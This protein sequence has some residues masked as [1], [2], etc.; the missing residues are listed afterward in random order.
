[1]AERRNSN[2]RLI[3]KIVHHMYDTLG[4]VE[5]YYTDYLDYKDTY[6][7]AASVALEMANTHLKLYMKWHEAVKALIKKSGTEVPQTM[8]DIWAYEH[9]RLQEEYDEYKYKLATVNT[10]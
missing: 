2:M 4:E 1:M 5:S 10:M 8:L 7:E 9:K 3:Q 6:P